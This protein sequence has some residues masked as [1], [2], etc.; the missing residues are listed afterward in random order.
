METKNTFREHLNKSSEI[1]RAWPSWKQN[2]PNHV[3]KTVASDNRA[4]TN[5]HVSVEKK[6]KSD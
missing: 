6:A 3:N 2:A 1:A 4:I 5:N